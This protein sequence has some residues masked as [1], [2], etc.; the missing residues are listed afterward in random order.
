[1]K[2][3]LIIAHLFHAS[4][5]IPAIAKYLSNFGWESTILTVPIKED[6]RYLLGFPSNFQE[7]VRIIEVSYRGD[8]FRFWREL[9]KLLG[10]NSNKSILNQVKEKTGTTS[11]KSFVDYILNFYMA[12]FAYPDEEKGWEKPALRV[13]NE[14]LEKEKFD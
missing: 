12:L 1:M 2:R 13:A 6:P 7:R 10:F 3:V 5:R 11:Q 14:L 4:P 8:I 9:F